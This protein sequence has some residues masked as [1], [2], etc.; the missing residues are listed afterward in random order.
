MGEDEEEA[1]IR[2]RGGE[3]DDE[4]SDGEDDDDDAFDNHGFRPWG[5]GSGGYVGGEGPTTC[6]RATCLDDAPP[7]QKCSIKSAA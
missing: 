6:C 2:P 3:E 4:D 5:F 7:S 1:E